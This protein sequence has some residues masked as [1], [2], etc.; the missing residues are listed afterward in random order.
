MAD[1][2]G[3]NANGKAPNRRTGSVIFDRCREYARFRLG[4]AMAAG[5]GVFMAARSI[6]AWEPIGIFIGCTTVGVALGATALFRILLDQLQVAQ[7][8]RRALWHSQVAAAALETLLKRIERIE[9]PQ[10]RGNPSNAQ[11]TARG[12]SA[13]P[14]AMVNLADVG[15]GNMDLLT[16]ATL[17]HSV[18]PRLATA[19]PD[20]GR[21]ADCMAASRPENAGDP[22][23]DESPEERARAGIALS[24]GVEP[25]NI[26]R[27]WQQAVNQRDLRVCRGIHAT[28]AETLE[29]DTLKPLPRQLAAVAGE[30]ERGLRKQFAEAVHRRDYHAALKIGEAICELLPDRPIAAE[31]RRV[32]GHLARRAV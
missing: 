19:M 10:G 24:Q 25:K 13:V 5:A 26:F 1:A 27:Q 15:E 32:R 17:D 3:H 16:A 14:T 4:A 12:P 11:S 31:F 23:A 21:E 30:V 8:S 29:P 6:S 7:S 20:E 28:L 2:P 22:A 9:Q 18:F